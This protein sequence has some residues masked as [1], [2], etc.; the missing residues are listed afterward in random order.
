[1]VGAPSIIILLMHRRFQQTVAPSVLEQAA[2]GVG[3]TVE[4]TVGASSVG[5]Q[6][7]GVRNLVGQAE[8]LWN[9]G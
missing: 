1:M 9:V 5:G 6:T 4:V 7:V 3:N 8:G 2:V